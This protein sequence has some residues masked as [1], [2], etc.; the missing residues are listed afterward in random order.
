MNLLKGIWFC[1][2]ERHIVRR[3]YIVL[4]CCLPPEISMI[5][6]MVTGLPE[7]RERGMFHVFIKLDP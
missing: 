7:V 6:A 4:Q 3:G 1:R 5:W 2:Q